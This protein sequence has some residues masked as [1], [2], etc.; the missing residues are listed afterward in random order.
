MSFILH[1]LY[2]HVRLLTNIKW[3]KL[4]QMM[5]PSKIFGQVKILSSHQITIQH[6]KLQVFDL[7]TIHWAFQVMENRSHSTCC[8]INR[9]W[10]M[11]KVR[12]RWYKCHILLLIRTHSQWR[13][14]LNFNN[15][16]HSNSIKIRWWNIS[17]PAISS[18]NQTISTININKCS[19]R[20]CSH[21]KH[22]M[23]VT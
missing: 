8:Y 22:P 20:N 1:F 13:L 17:I 21:L 2:I 7:S 18:V 19:E 12:P 15:I 10:I 4:A 23:A 14:N 6:Y 5:Q 9:I 3:K 11:V 16:R